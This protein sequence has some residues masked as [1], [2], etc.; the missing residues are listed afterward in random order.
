MALKN[1]E[2]AI[3]VTWKKEGTTEVYTSFRNFSELN[4][5]HAAEI[6][7]VKNQRDWR[8]YRRYESETFKIKKVLV[9]PES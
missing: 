6:K 4:P 9:N 1:N 3:I 2:Y 7:L 8:A 5:F